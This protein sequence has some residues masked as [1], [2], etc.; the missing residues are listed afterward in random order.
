MTRHDVIHFSWFLLLMA[1]TVAGV[2]VVER[3][4]DDYGIDS[5][6]MVILAGCALCFMISIFILFTKSK[7]RSQ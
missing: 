7:R 3:R 1:I 2:T 4:L 5:L 6:A